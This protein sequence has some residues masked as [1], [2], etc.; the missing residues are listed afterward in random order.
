MLLKFQLWTFQIHTVHLFHLW[1]NSN[2][3]FCNFRKAME[4]VSSIVGLVPCFYDHTSKH[5]V[6]IRDLRKNLQAL[7]EEMVDLNNLYEDVK[8]RVQ[9]EEQQEM[10][11]R[12]E[13]GGWIRKVEA[14]E[15]EVHEILQRGDQ[16]IQ[17]SCLGCCPRN[18]WSSYRIGKAVSEKLVAVSG[19]IGKGHFDVVAEMLPRPPVDELPMEATVGPQLAYEK[20]CRF[21][22]D[23]QVGIMGL[24]GMGG[25]GKTTLL[26]KINNEL[27]ATSN[28]FEV[29]IWAVVSK[30]PDIEK[31]Q[32]VIWNKLEIPR[33]KWE[34]RS[35]REEKAAEILRALKRK[36]FILLLDDIWEELDL[37]EMGVPRPDTENKSKIV[38]TTRSLDVCR[39]MKA[40]KSIEVECLES[41][42]AWTLFRKEVGEEILNSHPDIPMLA[43]VVAEECRGLPLALVTLG[44]AMAAEKDPSNWDKVIQDLR[45]SPAEITGMEDKLFHRLKLSYDRL[46]DNASKSCFIY[47]S[48]FR[49]DW[50]IYNFQ[51]IELWIGE[52]F[53]GEV[54]DIH[55]ARD[56]G[57]KIINTLKHAC[58]L[59]SCGSQERRNKI[60][61][62]NKVARLDEDQETSK[63]KETEKI[64]LWDMNVGKF[65]ETLVCPNL[66]T[67][68]V[69][70]CHNLKKFPNGFFQFM[71]LL[72]NKE[73][74]IELKNLK[75]LMILIMDGMKSLEIIPQDM[76]SS[77]ISLKLFSI[78]QSNI[79]SG[80]VETVLE[81]LE[82]L[83]DISEISITICNALSFNKLKSSHKLQRMEHL[84]ALYVSHCDKLKEVKIN[85]ERQGIHNDMTL[86]NKIAAREEY[87]H[88]LV[89]VRIR[90]CSKL[91]DLTWLVYAPYLEHLLEKLDIFS[92]LKYLKLNRLPRLKSIYQH[93]LL[94]PSLEIIKVYECKGLRSLPFDS[95]TSNNSLKKIKGETS[96]WNQLKWNNETCKHSFTPYFQIHEAEAYSTDTEESE[97]GSIDDVQEQPSRVLFYPFLLSWDLSF[98]SCFRCP[99]LFPSNWYRREPD[100]VCLLY[101][102]SWCSVCWESWLM[103]RCR[104]S[105]RQALAGIHVFAGIGFCG[106][107]LAFD[108]S[109]VAQKLLVICLLYADAGI[110]M[111][112]ALLG[113]YDM[114]M[115]LPFESLG[116]SLLLVFPLRFSSYTRVHTSLSSIFHC[117]VCCP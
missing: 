53:M 114:G 14:M 20:S 34:T 78:Y 61:V 79:T 93:P 71:L 69:Q 81:E 51:L 117:Q 47:H 6:Y 3:F 9:R 48:M 24:Y 112:V 90:H 66:K 42:D 82:S 44:R 86:P 27:L 77:L 75:N 50:E 29:V 62:Y 98:I 94:F 95:N 67:L 84:K 109:M 88:T 7:S 63:L 22:K 57:K 58:L 76:I 12:K 100:Y 11:C 17:K 13:V 23:P 68:F 70:K 116:V 10:K 60:L 32:Q 74:P 8:E 87:F 15:K 59:E 91:L 39:Q 108:W 46:P 19:Q 40:Q 103:S 52:G 45:K 31:I 65:P 106:L 73:L 105:S 111:V 5:T 55:E 2:P 25:V 107:P 89:K 26:K 21:L 18:C 115:L 83:N 92:R 96:W 38:L 99:A 56:Q 54:Q 30:S 110:F 37:L 85:V 104:G 1:L 113:Q 64:S 43:K 72:R 36:R 80:V 35:S 97:T 33:D 102:Y 49:E 4:F 101:R 41:E 28:D 16:E